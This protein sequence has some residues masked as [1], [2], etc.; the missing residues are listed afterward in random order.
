MGSSIKLASHE[1]GQIGIRSKVLSASVAR[2]V[3][4][5]SRYV[6]WLLTIL[7]PGLSRAQITLDGTVGSKGAL[8]IV[9]QEDS[10]AEC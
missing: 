9:L 8:R 5:L 10:E 2:H 6:L 7:L 4:M 3:P 1:N